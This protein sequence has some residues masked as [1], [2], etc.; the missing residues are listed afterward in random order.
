M[1]T[2]AR[3]LK[4]YRLA[5]VGIIALLLL[6]VAA[7]LFVPTLVAGIVNDGIVPGNMDR[8]WTLGLVMLGAAALAAV[9][10]L[11]GTYVSAYIATGISRDLACALYEKIHRLPYLDVGRGVASL[12]T[13]STSDVTQIQQ[14]FLIFIEMLLPVPFMVIIG[15][16]LM[17]TKDSALAVGM[18]AVMVAIVVIFLILSRIVIPYFEKLQRQLDGMNRTVRESIAGVRIVRA[19]RRTTSDRVRM[20]RAVGDYAATAITTNRIF[21]V[22]V[23]FVMLLFNVTTLAILYVGGNQVAEGSLGI[24]DIM[25]LVE[26]A[27]LIL[28]YLLMGVAMLIFIPQAQVSARRINE[29]L[30]SAEAPQPVEAPQPAAASEGSEAC[31]GMQPVRTQATADTQAHAG[32]PAVAFEHV[33]FSYEGAEQPV[34]ADVSFTA[35][36]GE[37][38][39]IVGATGSGKSTIANLLMGFFEASSG[40]VLVDGKPL[41]S[42]DASD[43][44]AKIGFVPQKPFLFSGTIA[45]NLRHGCENATEQQMRAALSTAQV[46]DFVDSLDDGLDAPVVQGGGNFSGGQR[47]RLAIARALVRHPEVLLF[48]DSFSALDATTDCK[49]RAA[50]KHDAAKS[51]KIVIAQR[52]SSI[53]DAERIVVL[54]EGR[55]VGMGTHAELLESCPDYRRIV[56]SQEG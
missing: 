33:T 43:L 35:W 27:M 45:D 34:L 5:C 15:L 52:V 20:E 41:N 56:Q 9:A 21:A 16:T 14:A 22:V 25:A 30:E 49:L 24:G 50:L 28:G 2:I 51:A 44:R 17:F 29:V 40:T 48:D 3:F 32:A 38:T 54:D 19:F 39:A 31:N 53:A 46:A 23:P 7:T 42:Y 37:T 36:P 47:Q 12:I 11:V 1:K 26:Y 55:V 13:R 10:T 8:V 4:G 6:Q 18:V